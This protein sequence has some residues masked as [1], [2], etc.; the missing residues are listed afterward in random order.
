ML[1]FPLFAGFEPIC[2]AARSRALLPVR[3]QSS[4]R[5][6]GEDS[7]QNPLYFAPSGASMVTSVPYS[8]EVSLWRQYRPFESIVIESNSESL[9]SPS[10]EMS[11]NPSVLAPNTAASRARRERLSASRPAYSGS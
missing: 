3:E 7:H 10:S 1:Y 6:S 11:L 2:A 4:P 8:N 5:S 9:Y